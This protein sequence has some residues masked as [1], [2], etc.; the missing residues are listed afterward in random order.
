MCKQ[1]YNLGAQVSI[2]LEDP[3]EEFDFIEVTGTKLTENPGPWDF[4]DY[5]RPTLKKAGPVN[6]KKCTLWMTSLEAYYDV[7]AR[8]AKI[9]WYDRLTV[10]I[11]SQGDWKWRVGVP[12]KRQSW[13]VR[14]WW[15]TTDTIPAAGLD[16][17]VDY[18]DF[19][20]FR[21]F[22]KELPYK[23]AYKDVHQNI[24]K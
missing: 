21:E 12:Q 2:E 7:V 18:G 13:T 10:K 1:F 22:L 19:E 9:G 4:E 24:L 20:E 6:S 23:V 16:V 15:G 14:D 11:A 5:S 8:F 17:Q 3:S